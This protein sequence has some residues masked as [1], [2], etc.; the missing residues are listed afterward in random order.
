MENDAKELRDLLE[1]ILDSIP[2]SKETG[3]MLS[4]GLDSSALACILLSKGR[5]LRSISASFR[6]ISM[7]DETE[8]I[9]MISRQY[10][11]LE[12][13]HTTPLDINLL[14][15]LKELMAII[16]IPIVS[17]SPLL[18]YLVMKKAKALGIKHL[19]Y[20]QWPDELMGGYD[21]FLLAKAHDDFLHLRIENATMN[22]KEY[23]QRSR[24]VKTDLILL[25]TIRTLVTS[26]GLRE[27]M[28]N[29]IPN[30]KYLVEI[31]K[32]SAEAL[33]INLILP[34]ADSKIVEFCQSL[35]PDRLVYRG[36]TK[37]ILREAVADIVP[38]DIT[39][40]RKKFGFFAPDTIW[41]LKNKDNIQNLADNA[42]RIEYKK[43]LRHPH[44]RWHKKLWLALSSAFISN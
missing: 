16:K 31:A 30:I 27:A 9:E 42:V 23:I 28:N 29:S 10:P 22:V 15:E 8:Y 12:T 35:N 14:D 44:K 43:F 32:K 24:M 1:R 41:L 13:N 3:I 21:P 11:Q 33:E 39:E 6:G 5:T 26:K 18:Q 34:Y 40:R 25:R 7:Y 37:V 19:L 36:Q 4:G 38:K 20:G 17:G 2:D